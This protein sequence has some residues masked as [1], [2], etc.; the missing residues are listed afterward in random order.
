MSRKHL[1]VFIL[2]VLFIP[3]KI[4]LFCSVFLRVPLW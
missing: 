2:S 1:F 4:F 3:V